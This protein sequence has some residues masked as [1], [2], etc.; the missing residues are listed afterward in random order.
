[1]PH[2]GPID[3]VPKPTH[4]RFAW[5]HPKAYLGVHGV[6]GLVLSAACAWA[7]F[8]I[9]DEFPEQGAFARLDTF[10]TTWL[11]THGTEI[12][13]SIFVGV[14]YLGAQVLIALL[15]IVAI[16]L[17][18]RRDWRHLVVLAA[19]CGGGAVLNAALKTIFHRARPTYATEFQAT[20]WS[21]PS[22]HAMDS[23]IVY[24]LFAYWLSRRW[25]RGRAAF[26][27]ATTLLIGAIGFARVY[28]G[29]HYLSDVL[30]GY[31]AGFAWL[32]VCVSGYRFAE[33]RRVGASGRDEAPK[34]PTD[35]RKTA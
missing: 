10:V 12:G 27:V 7:F 11:Q 22:G 35:A 26:F 23:L 6:V 9:A 19:T 31:S 5:L 28:L 2:L 17:I 20:S 30:A 24:G 34:A 14:S 15:V 13:E 1:M 18:V 4:S 29:V 32:V 8:A 21:F 25:P 3:G 33:A 16:V